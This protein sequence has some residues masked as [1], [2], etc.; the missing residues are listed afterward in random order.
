M[1]K[2]CLSQ[3]SYYVTF[4]LVVF[5]LVVPLVTS[6]Y[7]FLSVMVLANLYAMFAASWDILSGYTGKENFGHAL[8]I[9]AGAYGAAY[10]NLYLGVPPLVNLLSGGLIGA[11]FGILIGIPCLPLKGPYLALA[12]MAAAGIAERL[13]MILSRYTGGEEG[14]YGLEPMTSGPLADYYLSVVLLIASVLVLMG[15][16]YSKL[17]LILRSIR[18]DEVASEA[19][20]INTTRYK[21]YAFAV[22]AFFAGL[23]GA[24]YAHFQMSAGPSYLSIIMGV[25]VIIMCMVGGMGTIIGPVL[26]AFLLTLMNELLRA[27]GDLRLLIYTTLLVMIVL[28]LPRGI[29]ATLLERLPRLGHPGKAAN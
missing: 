26:G 12:T 15:I 16:G 8:F 13:T 5:L 10:L 6:D 7:Y 1:A 18:G 22:S 14:L 28:F 29:F 11:L 20:G 25:T 4:L 9:G 2:R 19:S 24:F 21:L 23:G 27:I 17:G 3:P